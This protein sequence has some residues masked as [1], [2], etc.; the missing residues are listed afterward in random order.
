MQTKDF[1]HDNNTLAEQGSKANMNKFT[2]HGGV[3]NIYL[4]LEFCQI[5]AATKKYKAI[6]TRNSIKRV[7]IHKPVA[8]LVL[9][10]PTHCQLHT[11]SM[12]SM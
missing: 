11:Y 2:F 9:K 4:F 12:H 6:K 8:K 3:G 5:Y 10:I 7:Y 1:T